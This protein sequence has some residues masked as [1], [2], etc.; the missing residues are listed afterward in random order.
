MEG[1][2]GPQFG[3]AEP[4]PGGLLPPAEPEGGPIG[5]PQAEPAPPLTPEVEPSARQQRPSPAPFPPSPE[6]LRLDR[7]PELKN[8]AETAALQTQIEQIITHNEQ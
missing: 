3:P 5:K 6:A 7:L 4:L 2:F 1:S 8:A